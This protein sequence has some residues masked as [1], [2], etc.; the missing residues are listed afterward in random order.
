[1]GKR[2]VDRRANSPLFQ[3]GRVNHG[4]SIRESLAG[5]DRKKVERGRR[6]E[7]LGREGCESRRNVGFRFDISARGGHESRVGGFASGWDPPLRA[8]L[9]DSFSPSICESSPVPLTFSRSF[10]RFPASCLTTASPKAKSVK[11]IG[12]G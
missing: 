2:T 12:V 3:D 5:L 4:K 7:S 11:V 8:S 9:P 6:E 1:M 10:V